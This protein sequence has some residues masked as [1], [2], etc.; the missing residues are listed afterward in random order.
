MTEL[1]NNEII[2]EGI[3]YNTKYESD[4]RFIPTH[5]SNPHTLLTLPSTHSQ[6]QASRPGHNSK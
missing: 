4:R 6:H 3:M 5:T 2:I 1:S